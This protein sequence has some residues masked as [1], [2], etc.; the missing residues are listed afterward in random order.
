MAGGAHPF[1]SLPQGGCNLAV[2]R[3][4]C[5]GCGKKKSV[6]TIGHPK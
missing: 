2:A 5:G 3:A 6:A 4:S 1:P